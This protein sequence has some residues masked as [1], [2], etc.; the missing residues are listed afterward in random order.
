M[1]LTLVLTV[2]TGLLPLISPRA[3]QPS[4]LFAAVLGITSA[5]TAYRYSTLRGDASHAASE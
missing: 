2:A 3:F 1:V 4:T 5:L